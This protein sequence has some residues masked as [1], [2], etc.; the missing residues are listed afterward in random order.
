[1]PA[2]SRCDRHFSTIHALRSVSGLSSRSAN[3]ALMRFTEPAPHF[4]CASPRARGRR[5]ETRAGSPTLAC[6]ARAPVSRRRPL[7]QDRVRSCACG[8]Q[9]HDRVARLQGNALAATPLHDEAL[10]AGRLDAKDEP[11]YLG[12]AD[13]VRRG[14]WHSRGH[15][16]LTEASEHRI[17]C[18]CGGQQC[19]A[20]P[21]KCTVSAIGIIMR[22]VAACRN[23]VSYCFYGYVIDRQ[24]P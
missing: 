16:F 8:F 9:R 3:A 20:W 22:H 4:R 11:L 7:G 21:R 12:V 19:V 14:A 24:K 5:R 1:M 23:N 10:D 18:K 15:V 6:A 13:F 2:F 17:P